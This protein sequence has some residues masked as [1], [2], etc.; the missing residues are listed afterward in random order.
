MQNHK[1]PPNSNAKQNGIDEF[2]DNVVGFGLVIVKGGRKGRENFCSN[3]TT[4]N[5]LH[6]SSGTI[7]HT[8][9]RY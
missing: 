7:V 9:L 3:S 5:C 4:K 1:L 8:T 6:V 2:C